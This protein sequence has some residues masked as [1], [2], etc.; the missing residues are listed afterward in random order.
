MYFSFNEEK[1][2]KMNWK[3]YFKHIFGKTWY[4]FNDIYFIDDEKENYNNSLE[5]WVNWMRYTKNKKYKYWKT[6]N[7]ILMNQLSNLNLLCKFH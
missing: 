1:T 2:K 6:S 4:A 3:S 5:L 7:R